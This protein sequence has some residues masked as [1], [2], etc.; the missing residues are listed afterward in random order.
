MARYARKVDANQQMIVKSLEWA[1]YHVT[2]LSGCG[3]GI[4]DLLCTINGQCLLIEI[5]NKDGANRFTPAQVE[6]YRLVK[7]PVFVIRDINDVESLI[8]GELL[9]I[10]RGKSPIKP[11]KQAIN[12][13]TKEYSPPS[14]DAG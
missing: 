3:R 2:D 8:K 1:G 10:N 14:T 4:P 6:Y 7:A 11:R 13:S 5:K 9:P 12:G